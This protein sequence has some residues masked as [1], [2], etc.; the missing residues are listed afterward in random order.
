ML[1]KQE[2]TYRSNHFRRL[3]QL[4]SMRPCWPA[5]SWTLWWKTVDRTSRKCHRYFVTIL[6]KPVWHIR[7]FY[8]AD[9]FFLWMMAICVGDKHGAPVC[10][11]N[12][13]DEAITSAGLILFYSCLCVCMLVSVCCIYP[14][15]WVVRWLLNGRV[16]AAVC[17]LMCCDCRLR[18]PVY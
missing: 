7:M 8:W 15:G 13:A 4:H 1:S 10:A 5:P 16:F 14:I 18:C 6:A 17:C 3:R 11:E 12:V 9:T 2:L